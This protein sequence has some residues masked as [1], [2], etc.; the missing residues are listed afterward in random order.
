MC[1]ITSLLYRPYLSYALICEYKQTV[2][3]LRY[4]TDGIDDLDDDLVIRGKRFTQVFI[5]SSIYK[6]SQ[7]YVNMRKPSLSSCPHKIFIDIVIWD[8]V[9]QLNRIRRI[10]E[11]MLRI[12]PFRWTSNFKRNNSCWYVFLLIGLDELHSGFQFL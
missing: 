9:N 10:I 3:V 1:L 6:L 11:V 12:Q 5:R 7:R 4:E 2:L 8:D